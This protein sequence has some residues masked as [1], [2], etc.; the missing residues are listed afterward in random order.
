MGFLMDW[1]TAVI[2]LAVDDIGGQLL[3][4][5]FHQHLEGFIW[6]GVLDVGFELGLRVASPEHGAVLAPLF[7]VI[8]ETQREIDVSQG[9]LLTRW[10]AKKVEV[11]R[12]V[13]AGLQ[14]ERTSLLQVLLLG[15]DEGTPV[16]FGHP[17]V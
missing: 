16:A 7:G 4:A 11:V 1:R 10:G 2:I 3:G 14:V 8:A 5:G 17:L 13:V 15:L 12:V 6:I 9:L